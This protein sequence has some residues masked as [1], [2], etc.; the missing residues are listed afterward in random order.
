MLDACIECKDIQRAIDYFQQPE[1]N[2]LADVIS[3]NT[4]MKGYIAAGQES[5]AKQL[6]SEMPQKGLSATR[7]SYHGL[8]NARVNARDFIA[9]WKLVS[10][11]Q[12]AGISPNAVTCSILLK[13]KLSSLSDVSK[14][15]ALIDAME[16]PMDEVLF[17]SV[18]ES[19]IRTNRLDLLSKQTEKFMS[20]GA[21]A[22][23]TAPTYGSMIK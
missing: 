20:Q 3:I 7:T 13:G 18:V 15:L 1:L 21:S 4:M 14:V 19:C 9:A 11:M 23:L 2:G 22:G 10:Q 16:E 12:A 8:L 5:A 17:L 6:L